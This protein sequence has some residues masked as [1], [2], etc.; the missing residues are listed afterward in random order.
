M[1]LSRI[2]IGSYE[3]LKNQ[4]HNKS[5]FGAKIRKLKCGSAPWPNVGVPQGLETQF[6][7]FWSERSA[8][9]QRSRLGKPLFLV[10]NLRILG[11]Q[12]KLLGFQSKETFRDPLGKKGGILQ[13][14]P[15]VRKLWIQLLRCWKCL[16]VTLQTHAGGNFH[17]C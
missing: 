7:H 1:T 13:S 4:R 15:R 2:F 11:F 3:V 17:S 5:P 12:W 14:C 6:Q 8:C 10:N 9:D 16:K